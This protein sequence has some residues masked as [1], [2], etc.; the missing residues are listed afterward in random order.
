MYSANG[1]TIKTFGLIENIKVQLS[2]YG[3][4]K[5]NFVVV[6]DAMGVEDFLPGRNF[7]Q[8]YQV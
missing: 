7:L 3:L 8:G 6:D 4:D 5:T 1:R 2:G